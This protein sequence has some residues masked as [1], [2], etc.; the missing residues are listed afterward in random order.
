MARLTLLLLYQAGYEVGRYI[1]L[2][3]IVERTKRV[4]TTRFISPL[5]TGT[6]HSTRYSG[7]YFLGR[8]PRL[9]V[10]LSSVLC[11]VTVAEAQSARLCLK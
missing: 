10:N 7:E 8:P 5:R 1:S 4:I 11:L 3:Q 9:T 6:Q 2:E